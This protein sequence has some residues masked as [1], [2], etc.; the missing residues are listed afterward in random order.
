MAFAFALVFIFTLVLAL[1]LL[2]FLLL[3]FLLVI[4]VPIFTTWTQYIWFIRKSSTIFIACGVFGVGFN[5]SPN[6]FPGT[7][8]VLSL[9]SLHFHFLLTQK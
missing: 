8:S 2:F 4:T 6:T 1:F 9:L 3:L 7:F 5:F